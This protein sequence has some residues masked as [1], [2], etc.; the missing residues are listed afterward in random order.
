MKCHSILIAICVVVCVVVFLRP[1][2]AQQS[3]TQIAA[4][5]EADVETAVGFVYHDVNENGARDVDEKGL[6]KVRVSNGRDIVTTDENGRYELSVDDDD[7]IFV[8]KPSGYRTPLSKN[9]LPRFYYIHKP[10]GSPEL[11]YKGVSPT[12][13]LPKSVDFPLYPQQEPEQFRAILFGDPQPRNQRE[14]DFIAHDVVE[15]LIG[16]DASFG[17]SLGDVMFDD[18]SL[19]GSLS[20]TIA[21]IGIPWYNVIGNHDI[22]YDAREDRFSDET[23]ERNFG[24][25]YYSFDYGKVHFLAIDDIDWHIPVG[26]PKAKYQGGIGQEQMEFIRNDLAMIPDDQLLV[27]MMHIP[28]TDV[29][30]RQDLYRLIEKRPF[31]MSISGHT[32][33][34]EHRFITKEDG[35]LGPEPHHHLIN[36]TVCGSWWGGAPDERGIPHATMADGA[37]NGY[38]VISFDGTK[39]SVEFKAAGKPT[40]YQMH[41]HAPEMV[42]KDQ[43]A[44]TEV[45]VNVF[46]ASQRNKVEMRVLKPGDEADAEAGWIELKRTVRNDPAFEEIVKIEA[47]GK[48]QPLVALPKPKGSTHLWVAKLPEDLQPGT[49]MIQVRAD[50]ESGKQHQSRRIIRIE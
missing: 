36:V 12:G 16:S 3:N 30:D 37:P 10:N 4:A 21:L 40:D 42:S 49:Y 7:I 39:Y 32:H 31:C 22:N 14:I 26:E 5:Q 35:F 15:E 48:E 45:T 1:V 43:A 24:P 50:V 23:F 11:R 6:A 20:D 9:K 46:N 34:H 28:L 47:T 27:L 29:Q 8:I 38:S 19:F 41:I 44:Q 17:V 33:H 2:T 18:L 13:P 25:S